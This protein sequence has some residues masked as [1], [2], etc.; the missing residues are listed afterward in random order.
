M[1]RFTGAKC[2]ET[3]SELFKEL[4]D[5]EQEGTLTVDEDAA[6]AEF[7]INDIPTVIEHLSMLTVRETDVTLK[8]GASFITFELP[9][10]EPAE[11]VI[12]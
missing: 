6:T 8:F 2:T 11:E 9:N 4:A 5:G 10:P 12:I 7:T 1:Y 3:N